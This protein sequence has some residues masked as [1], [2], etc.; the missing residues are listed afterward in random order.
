VCK[1]ITGEKSGGLR[2]ALSKLSAT[3]HIHPRLEAAFKAL[4]DYTSDEDGVRHAMLE[5]PKLGFA[6]AKFMLVACSAFMHFI[7]EKTRVSTEAIG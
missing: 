6:E 3:E 1:K 5:A 7:V 2:K 4:Y